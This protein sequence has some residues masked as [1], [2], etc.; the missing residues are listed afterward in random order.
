MRGAGRNSGCSRIL[1]VLHLRIVHEYAPAVVKYAAAAY[2]PR[3]LYV[4]SSSGSQAISRGDRRRS[5]SLPRHNPVSKVSISSVHYGSA[6]VTEPSIAG[7]D[8]VINGGPQH[9]GKNWGRQ[10][11][12]K[13]LLVHE[14]T[15][16]W[17]GEHVGRAYYS[18]NALLRHIASGMLSW[19]DL[20]YNPYAYDHANLKPWSDYNV[21][22]QADIV[23]D[24]YKSD[25]DPAKRKLDPRFIYIRHIIWGEPLAPVD[26]PPSARL[27]H[28][29]VDGQENGLMVPGDLFFDF[30]SARLKSEAQLYLWKAFNILSR[31]VKGKTIVIEGHADSTGSASHNQRLS[32]ERARAVKTWLAQGGF[33]SASNIRIKGYGESKPIAS[34]H[35]AEGRRKN[36]RVEF[37][38]E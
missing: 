32:L 21:E 37:R 23:E 31:N 34:N 10:P 33:P 8:Y 2:G 9:F 18:V 5:R 24:W 15:H 22:Q 26:D 35:T 25:S 7:K 13:N 20:N 12:L 27:A 17:Q 16:V 30:N 36:R 3:R 6:T 29:M 19:V 11:A 4:S 14:L 38:Y 28:V 1:F